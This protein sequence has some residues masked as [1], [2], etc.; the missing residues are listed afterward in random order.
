MSLITSSALFGGPH[1]ILSCCHCIFTISCRQK[2][3][4]MHIFFSYLE[5]RH[6]LENGKKNK[7]MFKRVDSRGKCLQVN[8]DCILVLSLMYSKKEM[9]D[10]AQFIEE[11]EEIII[12]L[13]MKTSRIFGV[14]LNEPFHTNLKK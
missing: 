2:T 8:L 1:L 14:Q 7:S 13:F 3:V 10:R 4:H 5:Q 12:S 9:L 11:E 6:V